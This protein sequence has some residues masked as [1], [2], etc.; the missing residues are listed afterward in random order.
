MAVTECQFWFLLTTVAWVVVCPEQCSCVN[1]P[2]KIKHFKYLRAGSDNPLGICY[3]NARLSWTPA[4]LGFLCRHPIALPLFCSP[5]L[6]LGPSGV[7]Q[8]IRPG[9]CYVDMSTVDADTVTELAQVITELTLLTAAVLQFVLC[10]VLY[11]LLVIKLLL[12]VFRLL[13]GES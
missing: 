6:V 1:V 4:E 7:L 8:G 11:Y 10:Q 9:K 3:C 12:E 2:T 13:L 5:Q